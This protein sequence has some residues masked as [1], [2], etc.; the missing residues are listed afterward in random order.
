MADL[1]Q[2]SISV[3]IKP[4]MII[5]GVGREMRLHSGYLSGEQALPLQC[6]IEGPIASTDYPCQGLDDGL[7]VTRT[8]SRARHA[9][10]GERNVLVAQCGQSAASDWLQSQLLAMRPVCWPDRAGTV[11]GKSR[12]C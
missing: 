6:K 10:A 11:K 12:F 2:H 3:I 8:N 9:A 5:L 7:T 1:N 4:L